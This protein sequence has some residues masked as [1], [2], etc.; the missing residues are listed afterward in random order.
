MY[1]DFLECKE[2]GEK[3][4]DFVDWMAEEITKR[5]PKEKDL[6]SR[7]KKNAVFDSLT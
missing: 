4:Q 5:R 1:G 6:V 3:Y 2:A 7:Y